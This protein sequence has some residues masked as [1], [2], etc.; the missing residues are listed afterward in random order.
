MDADNGAK[1]GR[2]FGV[3][4][5]DNE[6]LLPASIESSSAGRSSEL[7]DYKSSGCVSNV[8]I[9]V[10]AVPRVNKGG[11]IKGEKRVDTTFYRLIRSTDV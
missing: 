8:L 3:R 10:P 11:P 5:V 1:T 6:T 4:N 7:S 9:D 2:E